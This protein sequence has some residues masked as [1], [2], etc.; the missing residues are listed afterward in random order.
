MQARVSKVYSADFEGITPRLIEVEVDI[1]IGLASFNIVGLADKAVSEAKERVSSAIKNSGIKPPNRENRKI[2]VNLAPADIKK[3]GSNFDI[4][5]ALGYLLSSNQIKSFETKNKLFLG[6]LAL[7]GGVRAVAGVLNICHKANSL[8]FKE[9][10]IPADNIFEVVHLSGINII[11]IKT[12]TDLINHLE[13][14]IL[15]QPVLLKEF[16]PQSLLGSVDISEI[17]GQD[18]AKRALAIAAAGSHN[19]FMSGSPGTGKTMLAQSLVSILPDI[20]FDEAIDV[21]KIYSAAGLL[22]GKPFVSY[23][24]FRSPHHSASL[25]SLVGGGQ[26]PKPGEVS[27]AHRGVLFLD[28]LPEFH[29]DVLESLRQP[30]EQGWVT[31]TRAKGSVNFPSKF[32]LVAAANPCPC[33]YFQDEEK[34]CRCSPYE[35]I[36]YQKRLSGPLLDRID[37]NIWVGRLTSGDIRKSSDK[38]ESQLIKNK[39]ALARKI[40]YER[41]KKLGVPIFSNS[42]M[43]SKQVG[44]IVNI[45]SSARSMLGKALD[46]AHISARGYFK[47]IK[48]AQTIADMEEKNIIDDAAIQEAFSYRVRNEN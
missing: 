48:V 21:T 34:E 17:K 42:E 7:D 18:T 12:L 47:I 41:F 35:V 5:I 14:K 26:N 33:G 27:L 32:M 1:N 9:V 4:A 25:V 46:K 23:R 36:K 13:S 24:P 22:A 29:R 20:T 8:G 44:E 19:I 39:V 2:T 31:I 10:Y 15:I 37:I 6:E 45:T 30:I 3:Q 11:P 38:T 43:S 28:E 16:K 40:Q